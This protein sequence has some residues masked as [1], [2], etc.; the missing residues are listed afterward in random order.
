[1]D[2]R[3]K[4]K[5]WAM[6]VGLGLG[7]ATPSRADERILEVTGYLVQIGKDDREQPVVGGVVSVRGLENPARSKE[8]G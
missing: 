6:S 7:M 2:W 4:A 3:G 1:M 8:Q 5:V